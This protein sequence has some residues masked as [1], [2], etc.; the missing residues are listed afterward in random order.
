MVAAIALRT[1]QRMIIGV[2]EAGR[3]PLAG[4]V[5]VGVVCVPKGFKV[6]RAFPGVANSKAISEKE[7]ERIYKLVQER[8]KTGEIAFRARFS[9]ASAIDA[10]G[11]TRAVRSAVFRGVR[12]LAPEPEGVRVLL[13]GLL[14]APLEYEQKTI[15]RGDETIAIISL[16]SIVAKVR[17]DRRMKRLAKKYPEYGMEQ[18]KGYGTKAHY[19]AIKKHG[20]SAIHRRTFLH[21]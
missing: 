4:P 11:I 21:S 3:G 15:I 19:K 1:M 2:D 8:A 9:S 18:H 7:R 12:A 14:Q 13:D 16:A 6:R 20:P 17:R 5:C 10:K